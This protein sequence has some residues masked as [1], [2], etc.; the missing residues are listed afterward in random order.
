MVH[1]A[2]DFMKNEAAILR[3]LR[4]YKEIVGGRDNEQVVYMLTN[5]DT[6]IE[7]DLYRVNAIRE[8][9]FCPDVRIYRKQTAPRVLKDLQRWCNNRFIFRSCDFMDYVPRKDGKTVRELYFN[10]EDKQ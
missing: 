3:G 7:Q 4:T 5:F 6:T 10:G 1:F 2:F 8:A 9:G